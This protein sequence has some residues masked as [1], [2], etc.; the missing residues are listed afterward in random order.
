MKP[1]F[2]SPPNGVGRALSDGMRAATGRY[3][4]LMD[5]DFAQILPE[6]RDMFDQA[7]RGADVVLGSRFSRDSV[8]VN[9]PLQKILCN[10]LFHLLASVAFHRRLR[11]FTNN[12]KLLR[13]EVVDNLDLEAAW[14][15]ANAETGLKPLLM[16]YD[17]RPSPISWINRTPEMGQSSFSLLKNGMGYARI[18]LGLVW[19]TRFGFRPLPRRSSA[20]PPAAP[21]SQG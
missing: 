2:R 21:A 8:L 20:R 13:R 16:G 12:L 6:L 18:L 11:D 19:K 17:V 3:V 14:F 10:R 7:A 9:Y 1:V 5:C 15:A 4:L